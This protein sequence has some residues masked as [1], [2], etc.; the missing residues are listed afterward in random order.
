MKR[1][2]SIKN[3]DIFKNKEGYLIEVLNYKRYSDIE[4]R[5]VDNGYTVTTQG[6]ALKIGSVKNPFHP[7][8][9]GKGFMGVGKYRCM[10][11]GLMTK[12]YVH[13]AAMMNR[14][15]NENYLEHRPY[16]RDVEVTKEWWNFQIFAEWCQTQKGF[17]EQEWHLDKDLLVK[18]NKLYSPET[19][20]F[21]PI[22]I[23]SFMLKS[24]SARGDY[25]IGVCYYKATEMFSAT[26]REHG[27]AKHL[28][29]YSTPEEAFKAYANHKWE[30]GLSLAISWK[31]KLDSRAIKTLANYRV[32]IT[33]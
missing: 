5:F 10:Q 32:E 19:C 33:D 7:D 8:I 24:D 2:S 6:N 27:K 28:G 15:Y 13:W 4:V 12:E 25:P 16:Y 14:C 31:E 22:E 11:E 20:C 29:F 9:C 3:G 30:S 17:T 23:N 26:G 21:L 18:G 1:N